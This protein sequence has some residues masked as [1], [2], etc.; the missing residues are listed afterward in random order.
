MDAAHLA[1]V[2][3]ALG[4]RYD[5]GG[6]LGTGGMATVYRARD[7]RH[8]RDVAVK[9]LHPDVAAAIGPERF[10]REIEIAAGLMHPHIL[11]LLDSGGADGL[12]WYVMPLVEGPSL[13]DRLAREGE[14]PVDEALAILRDLLDALAHAHARGIVHRDLKPEN[15]LLAGGRVQLADFGIAKA[16]TE[17]AGAARLT[18]TGMAVGTPAYM[19]PEQAAGDTQVDHRADLYALGVL[20]YE[21]LAGTPPFR[22]ATAQHLVAAHLTRTPEP[23]ADLRPAVPPAV[24]A[25]IMRC[26]AKR[27]ADRWQSAAELRRRLEP[28]AA[29]PGA[30]GA[31]PA[32]PGLTEGA[33]TIDE[34][35]CRRLDRAVFDPRMIGDRLSYLD[36]G[37]ASDVLVVL[38]NR[39]GLEAHASA[40]LIE[41]LPWRTVVPTLYGFE[42]G[43]QVRFPLGIG[44]HAVLLERLLAYLTAG[45]EPRLVVVAGF[46]AGA[47][48]MLRLAAQAGPEVRLDGCL[49][50]G[51]NL[52]IETCFVSG[53]L[54]N[55]TSPAPEVVLPA[56]NAALGAAGTVRDWVNVA[57]YLARIMG[58]F[59][60]D[61]GPIRA[62]ARDIVAPWE[63][64][65]LMAFVGW[66]RA[67][68]QAGR[69]LRVVF[70]DNDA[71]RHN[72][73][74]LQLRQLDE[75]LLGPGW[76]PGSI[77]V[78]PVASHFDLMEPDCLSRHLEAL[79]ADLRADR[80]AA[81][82][83]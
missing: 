19:A 41:A 57:D 81:G 4:D 53:V 21:M 55:V 51:S 69:R 28:E 52:G 6:A 12:L 44:D 29:G 35:I 16:L 50:L 22:G 11:S 3:S 45:A 61:L 26:L 24:A 15:V 14:L 78:E 49:S 5:L 47:D 42:R 65:G 83:R 25:A 1:R 23:I 13:R 64:D 62:F 36:N 70:E 77:V 66:Y 31:H 8:R 56:L 60:D 34:E 58:I 2:R 46:S 74:Q 76:Q 9:V 27:P 72:V 7:R 38:V 79:V 37:A 68:R 48:L 67:A 18:A 10:L 43:R 32:G 33:L 82:G 75:G 54:A 39:W 73:R 17:G 30:G 63:R 71:Y 80:T 40:G 20:A 59:G